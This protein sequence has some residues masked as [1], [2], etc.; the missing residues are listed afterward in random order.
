MRKVLYDMGA[1]YLFESVDVRQ[2]IRH[3]LRVCRFGDQG[4]NSGR[5]RFVLGL[6]GNPLAYCPVFIAAASGWHEDMPLPELDSAVLVKT[7]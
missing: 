2:G 1:T 5:E 4:P 3:W 7:W 6:P